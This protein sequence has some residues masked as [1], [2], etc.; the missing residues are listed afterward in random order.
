MKGGAM[1]T[2]AG[3]V[4]IVTGGARGLGA[5]VARGLAKRGA[6]VVINYVRSRE[7][8]EALVPELR[9]LGGDGIAVRGDVSADADC[10]QIARAAIERWGRIDI[11]INNAAT[12][13]RM[14]AHDDLEAL[15]ADDFLASYRTNVIGT[16]QMIRACQPAM[17]A[18]GYGAVVNISS[19]GAIRGTG[20]SVSYSASKGAL[21]NMTLSLARA[22]GPEIRVNAVCPG[23]MATQWFSDAFGEEGLNE[24]VGRQRLATPLQRAGTPDDVAVSVL[25]LADEGAVHNTGTILVCDAGLQLGPKAPPLPRAK[26]A[27]KASQGSA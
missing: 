27:A 2:L 13:T 22:L 24:L 9:A 26:S 15:Q 17:K 10:R 25:F 5:A 3:K 18:Q 20:T 14:A 6:A 4:A 7:E 19:V 16:F 12:T 8:A 21:N 23:F 1:L 11:L